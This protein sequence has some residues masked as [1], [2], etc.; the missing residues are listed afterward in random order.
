M[1]KLVTADLRPTSPSEASSRLILPSSFE[2]PPEVGAQT[3]DTS[4]CGRS[5]SHYDASTSPM[6]TFS[7]ISD[8]T[9]RLLH[10]PTHVAFS[11]F[12]ATL[13]VPRCMVKHVIGRGGR[14]LHAIEDLAHCLVLV[15]DHDK[16]DRAVVRFF[17][18][19][20][21][22]ARFIVDALCQGHHSVLSTLYRNGISSVVLGPLSP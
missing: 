6:C 15:S 8:Y 3:A 22:L 12:D 14:I 1:S 7:W 20:S 9:R 18:D 19:S 10:A 2:V 4:A 16:E 13:D 11:A 21:G 17:G 5:M